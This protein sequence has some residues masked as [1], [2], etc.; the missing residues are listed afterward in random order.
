MFDNIILIVYRLKKSAHFIPIKTFITTKD[1]DGLYIKDIGRLRKVHYLL[2]K[3]E[4][5][6]L[7]LNLGSLCRKNWEHMLISVELST[8][9]EI[10]RLGTQFKC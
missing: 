6:N 2:S 5:H 8:L 3:I 7:P 4:R 1:Y 9:G 10:D